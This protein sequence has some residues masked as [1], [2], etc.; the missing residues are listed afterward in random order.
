[1]NKVDNVLKVA[2]ISYYTVMAI[3]GVLSTAWCIMFYGACIKG[4]KEK[5][6]SNETCMENC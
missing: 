1:M 6:E 4:S 5:E 2:K 3:G